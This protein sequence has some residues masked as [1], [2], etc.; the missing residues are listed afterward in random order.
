MSKPLPLTAA[1]ETLGCKV[2][3]YESAHLLDLLSSAGFRIVPFRDSADLYLVHSCAVTAKAA[4]QTRQ[5]LRRAHRQNPQAHIVVAGCDAQLEPDRLAGERLATHILGTMEKYR[6]LEFLQRPASREEPFRATGNPRLCT[7]LDPLPVRTLR[8]GR[9]R[10]LLKIQDGCDAFCT[11]C[12]IPHTRGKSRSLPPQDVL[13]Q[14]HRFLESG[15]QE[16]I[17]TGIHLGRWGADF[18]P[19]KDL[20]GLLPLMDDSLDSA[21]IRM[22]SLEPM[23]LTASLLITL[24]SR[25]WIC[26]HFHIPLQNGDPEILARMGR[27]YSPGQYAEILFELHGLF[28]EASIGADV[29]VG[30]PG[31]TDKHFRNTHSLIERLPLTYL[32]V[33]PFS[34]RSGVPAGTWSGRPNGTEVKRRVRALWEMGI[35]KRNTFAC[36]FVG[37]PLQVLAERPLGSGWWQGTS[38]NYLRVHFSSPTVLRP[39]ALVDVR[40]E[41]MQDNGLT[42]RLIGL[43]S[44]KTLK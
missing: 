13:A 38:E 4:F 3:Q 11:Y 44:G 16:V 43:F 23:E 22:S 36:R 25:P 26:P 20:C 15:F 5:L 6:L 10:A 33:F 7:V 1:V 18:R 35:R 34:P 8:T 2:N 21:R 41:E 28:P 37:R 31:E 32:H 39:G 40:C 24:R 9:A 17:L 19:Q 14:L 12:V 30:F 42:G 27:P 29:M